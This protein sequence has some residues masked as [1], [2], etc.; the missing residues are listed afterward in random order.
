M[1]TPKAYLSAVRS[2]GIR[3]GRRESA[4]PGN[5]EADG[6]PTIAPRTGE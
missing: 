4:C 6:V 1:N 2:Q 5:R 3:V